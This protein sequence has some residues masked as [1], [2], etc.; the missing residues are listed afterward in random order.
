MV[1]E[2]LFV[3]GVILARLKPRLWV[4]VDASAVFYF[5]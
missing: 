3:L 1:A 4:I 5:G 2:A